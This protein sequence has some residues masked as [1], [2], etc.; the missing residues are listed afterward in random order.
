LSD[1]IT[2]G[3]RLRGRFAH[4]GGRR[5]NSDQSLIIE[6]L[7]AGGFAAELSESGERAF[8][9]LDTGPRYRALITDINLGLNKVNGW[10]VAR[11][12]REIDP[13]LPVIYMTGDC[14][15]QWRSQGVPDS[16]LLT[17]PFATAQ[18][19]TAVSNLLNTG[20]PPVV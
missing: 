2:I 19:V 18:I 20:T 4:I 8:K 5:R 7:G 1:I 10:Q 17:K 9:L 13:E 12:A 16:I 11:Y 3:A 14:A 15:V 6:A